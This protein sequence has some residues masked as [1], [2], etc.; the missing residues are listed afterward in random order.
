MRPLFLK[1]FLSLALGAACLQGPHAPV[2]AAGLP[3]LEN[4]GSVGHLD[5]TNQKAV[6]SGVGV[7]MT[8]ALNQA[9]A[10]ASAAR[11]A[12]VDAQRNLLEVVKKVR[13]DSQ[14]R[15]ENFMAVS[16]VVVTRI[17]GVLQWSAL[18]EETFLQDGTCRVVMS[19]PLTGNLSREV[20]SLPQTP[21]RPPSMPDARLDRMEARIGAL[22]QQLLSL[23]RELAARPLENAHDQN[24]ALAVQLSDLSERLSALESAKAQ[25]P[26]EPT[27]KPAPPAHALPYT[28][29]V[30]DAR[31]I[32]FKPCLK[33]KI[34]CREKILYPGQGVDLDTAI[35]RGYV[36]YYR[37]LAQ[38]QQSEL[39]GG[40]PYTVKPEAAMNE[41]DLVLGSGDAEILSQVLA[42]PENF[43]NL[44]RVVV[45]F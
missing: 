17:N 41:S 42:S 16:D 2:F 6:A 15:V 10:R 14:T 12:R 25:K 4:I 33:P 26:E 24:A 3:G 28:G 39:A 20:L 45:V 37:D 18:E 31:A 9:Q 35:K 30:V 13:I 27:L 38:A 36:R 40:T 1:I 43:L 8:G 19:V 5:W 29:L 11:A 7:P 23:R 44:C 32:G 22:E 34:L 21:V